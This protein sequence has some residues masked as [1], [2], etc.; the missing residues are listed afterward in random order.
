[1]DDLTLVLSAGQ[2]AA[3]AVG[4]QIVDIP[5]LSVGI[6]FGAP[7]V[8]VPLLDVVKTFG[9]DRIKGLSD[10]VLA[11]IRAEIQLAAID[12]QSLDETMANIQRL[13]PPSGTGSGV[14]TRAEAI[15]RTEVG[16]IHSMAAQNRMESL[17][18]QIP[19]LQKEW[20][21]SGRILNARDGHVAASGQ[22]VPVMERFSVA[23]TV[24]GTRQQLLY[25]RDPIATAAN[26]VFC[27]CTAAVWLQR[28]EEDE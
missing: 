14:A 9:A 11:Q 23:P 10:S 7:Q 27:R 13:L 26:S 24:G 17:L 16:R 2:D 8:T 1:A 21:H 3:V 19:D 28:W 4:G 12:A 5:L 25:P 22:R 18:E 15:V 20:R 6:E